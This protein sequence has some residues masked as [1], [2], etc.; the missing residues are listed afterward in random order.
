MRTGQRLGKREDVRLHAEILVA[1]QLAR[2]AQ[3]ALHLVE[4]LRARRQVLIKL[5][6]LHHEGGHTGQA[7]M[8]DLA[9]GLWSLA[10]SCSWHD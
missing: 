5:S 9:Q 6:E 10:V 1:K 2:P 8:Q 3:A 7:R 4:H